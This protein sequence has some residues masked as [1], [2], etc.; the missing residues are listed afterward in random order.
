MFTHNQ[1]NNQKTSQIQ[2]QQETNEISTIVMADTHSHPWTMIYITYS[3]T[4]HL[5]YAFVA[6]GAVV[7][8]DGFGVT[9][10]FAFF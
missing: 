5:Q 7:G 1:C 9:A 3:L 10:F 4:I 8:T 2:I 6:Y